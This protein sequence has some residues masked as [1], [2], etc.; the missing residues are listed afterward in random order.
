ME[1]SLRM[2][3][4]TAIQQ[5]CWATVRIETTM[6]IKLTAEGAHPD[7]VDW[8]AEA[9]ALDRRIEREG[10]L[11]VSIDVEYVNVSSE[12]EPWT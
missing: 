7:L 12:T 3:E 9:I 1:A 2:A 11:P 8:E 4:T 5:E 6:H 10:S